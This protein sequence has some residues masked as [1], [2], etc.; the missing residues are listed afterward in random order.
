KIEEIEDSSGSEEENTLT[1]SAE[2]S[3]SHYEA[4]CYYCLSKKS[5][6]R[7]KPAK[8]EAHL[9]NEC[10]TSSITS[11][12][13][14]DHPLP[15]ATISQLDQKITKA[16]IIA[17]IPF[18]VIENPFIIDIFKEFLLAYNLP[19]RGTLSERLLDEEVVQINCKFLTNKISDIVEKLGSDKFAAVVTNAAS[20][21]NSAYQKIQKMYLHIWNVRCAAHAVNLIASDLVKLDNLKKLIVNCRKNNNFFNS[22]HLS[23]LLLVKGFTDMKIKGDGLKVWLLSEHK[24]LITN[25]EIANLMANEDFFTMCRLVRSVWQPIKEVIYALETNEATL[26]DST[27]TAI[28]IWQSLGHT[29]SES[30]ELVALMRR[31]EAKILPFDLSYVSGKDTP[32]IWW[33]SFKKQPHLPELALRIFFN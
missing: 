28:E 5:L 33:R 32:K 2:K 15:K 29:Q 31:F 21:C 13:S 12:F 26:A 1:N 9:A 23:Y 10:P 4:I 14:S 18:D 6:A 7:E 25:Q 24:E 16:W 27:L 8:L 22:S 17:G 20:N 3:H 30:N 19:S 11:H